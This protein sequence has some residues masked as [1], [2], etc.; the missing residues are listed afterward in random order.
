M[1]KRKLNSEAT[2]MEGI[3]PSMIESIT[4][5]KSAAGGSNIIINGITLR[6]R[7]NGYTPLEKE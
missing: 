7:P 1:I 3:D 2:G 5:T 6:Q 4:V